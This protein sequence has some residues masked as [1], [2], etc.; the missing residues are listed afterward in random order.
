M[1]E[2]KEHVIELDDNGGLYR[3]AAV[4]AVLASLT[5]GADIYQYSGCDFEDPN[6]CPLIVHYL[7]LPVVLAT[8]AGCAASL[9]KKA[10]I[11]A[12]YV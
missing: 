4:K 12:S 3:R 6:C 9:C 5:I 2:E 7:G 11:D 8:A 10:P 1:T